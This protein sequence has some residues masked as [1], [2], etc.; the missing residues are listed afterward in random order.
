M[1]GRNI[2]IVD[3]DSGLLI[4]LKMVFTAK[5]YIV[6]VADDAVAALA[7]IQRR[8]PDIFLS[9]LYMPGMN[10]IELLAIVAGQYPQIRTIAMCAIFPDNPFP[11]DVVAHAFY[12]K[13]ESLDKLFSIVDSMRDSMELRL[14]DSVSASKKSSGNRT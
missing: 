4:S 1:T 6:T 9:D 10:G 7:E 13:A 12:R 14:E 2:L 8:I 5:G 11:E 3:D